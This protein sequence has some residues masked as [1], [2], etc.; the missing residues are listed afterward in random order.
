MAEHGKQRRKRESGQYK[1]KRQRIRLRDK[2]NFQGF[3]KREARPAE[4]EYKSSPLAIP[5]PPFSTPT[6]PE[7]PPNPGPDLLKEI[8]ELQAR[9]ATLT[10]VHLGLGLTFA[11]SECAAAGSPHPPEQTVRPLLR[12]LI[13]SAPFIGPTLTAGLAGARFR[14]SLARRQL[15][16]RRCVNS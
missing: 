14:F 16:C 6:K 9:T 1:Q 5:R 10:T 12:P 8:Y 4:P 2:L 3:R 13:Q 11:H 15:K 7:R